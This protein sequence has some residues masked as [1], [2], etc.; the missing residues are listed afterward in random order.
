MYDI[1]KSDD[2]F[3]LQLLHKRNLAYSGRRRPFL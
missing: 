2:V 3:M 1:V